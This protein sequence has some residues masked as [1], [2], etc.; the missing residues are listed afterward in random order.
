MIFIRA[1][2]LLAALVLLTPAV[3]FD[4]AI[5][6]DRTGNAVPGVYE[7]VC[8]DIAAHH[9][10]FIINVG[11]TIQGYDDVNTV[12]EWNAVRP[13][14][15][16]FGDIPFYLVPGNHDIWSPASARIW[17]TQTG[18]PPQYSFDFQDAHITVLD[19]SRADD[20]GPDQL[21]FLESDLAA[22]AGRQPKFIFFHRPFWL[23]PVK[24]QNGDFRL[25]RIARKYGVGF[26]VSG[27]A[28]IFDRSEYGGVQYVMVGSSGGSLTHEADPKPGRSGLIGEYFGYAWVH[29][30]GARATLEFRRV[31]TPPIEPTEPHSGEG[32][33]IRCALPRLSPSFSRS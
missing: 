14:W 10:A 1:L 30:E 29:V 9:P 12:D 6:G 15:K 20:L 13:V 24:F 21:D 26:V 7:R 17:R 19:N 32:K 23:L 27:H 3:G 8:K 16:Y 25:H 5:L 11:D 2:V 18:H 22:N 31:E 33:R 4:F 28:H